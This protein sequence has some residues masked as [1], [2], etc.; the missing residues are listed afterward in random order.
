VA[1]HGK[2]YAAAAAKIENRPYELTAA[3]Q[4]AKENARAGFDETM[5]MA[6]RLGVDPRHADQMVRGTLVLPHGTG[7]ELK[8]LVFA[9]G[10]KVKEAEEAGADYVGGE[11]LAKKIEGGWVDFDS[12]V[13]TP[14]M[15]KVAGKLGRVL[16]PRG[17]MPNPKTGTVTFDLAEA[18]GQI[19]AG[20]IEFRVEKTGIIHAPFGK[21]SFTEEQLGENARALIGAILKAKPAAA[22]GKYVKSAVISTTMGPGIK[23]DESAVAVAEV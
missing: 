22:K 19:K 5:E 21:A 2:K 7:R 16:G 9:Q 1:K 15:M 8:V 11:D 10:E 4:L 6:L 18:I 20:R 12:V 13:S 14:D 3:L 17:M 23:L